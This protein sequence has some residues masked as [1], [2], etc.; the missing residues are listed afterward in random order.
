MFCSQLDTSCL[1]TNFARG[2]MLYCLDPMGFR[3]DSRELAFSCL[4]GLAKNTA[5]RPEDE[6]H[7]LR[8]SLDFSTSS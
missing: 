4:V 5:F 6:L 8:H 2:L 1:F 7:V 3:P